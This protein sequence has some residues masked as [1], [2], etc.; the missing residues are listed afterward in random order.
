[1]NPHVGEL[2][3]LASLVDQL[4]LCGAEGSLLPP[5]DKK[6]KIILSKLAGSKISEKIQVDSSL[7]TPFDLCGFRPVS[8][9]GE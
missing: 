8:K 2:T 6:C 7:Q 1:M 3:K 9:P 5:E 4:L